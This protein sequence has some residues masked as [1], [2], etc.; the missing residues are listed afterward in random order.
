MQIRSG[1]G[2]EFGLRFLADEFV[3]RRRV[4]RFFA[5]QL[6]GHEIELIAMIQ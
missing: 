5:Q 2:R 1:G 3:E 4:E 6:A